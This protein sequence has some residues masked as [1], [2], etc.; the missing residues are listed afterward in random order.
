M[1]R[2]SKLPSISSLGPSPFLLD[3]SLTDRRKLLRSG[4]ARLLSGGEGSFSSEARHGGSGH[5][6]RDSER[7][8]RIRTSPCAFGEVPSSLCQL[9]REER[10]RPL[11]SL[12][13][14]GLLRAISCCSTNNS[15][16][17]PPS[18]ID[19]GSCVSQLAWRRRQA[20]VKSS[21]LAIASRNESLGAVASTS[22]NPAS[23]SAL[24]SEMSVS[25]RRCFGEEGS[26]PAPDCPPAPGSGV[27]LLCNRNV[28]CGV[29]KGRVC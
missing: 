17:L 19:A 11:V 9:P 27:M 4:M 23:S 16:S 1:P 25:R 5:M 6:G 8:L 29:V 7:T 28:G 12:S 3:S 15:L 10:G 24:V 13:P 18:S 20:R 21:C 22:A 14:W 2:A 26:Q